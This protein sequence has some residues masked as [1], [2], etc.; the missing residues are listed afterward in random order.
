MSVDVECVVIGAGV[1][2]LAVA[3]ALAQRGRE[4]VLAEAESAI[5]TGASSRN[6]EVIHAG[7]YYPPGSLKARLCVE[8]RAKLYAFCADHG[9]P[10]KRT[11][12]LIVA[13][14]E[15]QI[16]ELMRIAETA[17]RNGVADLV[18][19]D[20]QTARSVEPALT[21]CAALL[22]PSTGILDSHAY[23]LA[24]RGEA[25]SH[26]AN[27][28]LATPFGSG[29][30][31]PGGFH[32]LFAD[33]AQTALTCRILINAAGL[34]APAAARTLAGLPGGTIPQAH[35][36]KGS[37]F[38]LQGRAPFSRLIYLLPEAAGLGI[39]LTLDLGGGAKF[40][41]DVEWIE[42]LDFS[43]DAAKGE[44]FA[45]AIRAFWADL[46]DGALH[47]AFCG[48]RPKISGP[49]EPARDFAI[50][51]PA[52]HGIV[53]LV[54]LFGIESPG[55]TASLAIADYVAEMISH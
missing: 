36:C 43:M 16:P 26:G 31:R 21:C 49:G 44:K 8:G 45:A 17:R 35:F 4:V 39:H 15:T 47:P 48:I 2:G 32:L 19:L 38:A 23:L 6:S 9:V 46:P 40:G 28:A 42:R 29:A 1:L 12:K 25:E 5:G 52:D 54:N 51:G 11:G 18:M 37:Y 34:N 3:R 20:R 7:L 53:G 22:S 50:L 27:V 14:R 55:L 10:T 33:A 41:P 13:T 30:V 24:L